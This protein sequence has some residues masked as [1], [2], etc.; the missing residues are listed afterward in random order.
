MNMKV[1]GAMMYACGA[2]A[3]MSAFVLTGWLEIITIFAVLV[4]LV[5]IGPPP[6]QEKARV[7]EVPDEDPRE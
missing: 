1:Y 2:L 7:S 4:M 3:A 5:Y 6:K